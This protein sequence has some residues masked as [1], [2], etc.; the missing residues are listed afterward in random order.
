MFMAWRAITVAMSTINDDLA[1]LNGGLQSDVNSNFAHIEQGLQTNPYGPA[2]NFVHQ[3]PDHLIQLVT[4]RST[5]SSDGHVNKGSTNGSELNKRTTSLDPD[6]VVVHGES[7][8]KAV[9]E[10]SAWSGTSLHPP[11]L[12]IIQKSIVPDLAWTSILDIAAQG[13][14]HPLD[15][16][17]LVEAARND[18][19]KRIPLILFTSETSSGNPK[20][21]PRT[22]DSISRNPASQAEGVFS[23]A[24]RTN[25]R[26]IVASLR[27]A[28]W[29]AGG[30]AV[31]CD[32]AA[33][34]VA[35]IAAIRDYGANF[36]VFIPTIILAMF[37]DAEFKNL[38]VSHMTKVV[39]GGDTIT[40]SMFKVAQEKFSKA[41]IANGQTEGDGMC[42]S[43]GRWLRPGRL[44]MITEN[45]VIYILGRMKDIIK[46][47]GVPITP[48]ALVS[49][50]WSFTGATSS[51][52]ACPHTVLG[53][54]PLV[55][56]QDLN[57]KTEDGIRE[58]CLRMFANHYALAPVVSFKQ[59]GLTT[60]PLNATVRSRSQN[61]SHVSN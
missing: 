20:S 26:V 60:F 23:P 34:V 46:R 7:G 47:A 12:K 10:V 24:S 57:G 39:M 36:M 27:L 61:C 33:G 17:R 28:V 52:L 38:D 6:V 14:Q 44:A 16:T 11:Q 19:F 31:M 32:P 1:E 59:L 56:V 5:K 3:P 4:E 45:G 37:A 40:R 8:A 53:R 48:A 21:C 25:L 22:I 18:D 58:D 13:K 49:C 15:E 9:D 2:T 51:V 54:E 41:T 35:Q 42:H 29:A 43:H 50:I 55:V 30:C